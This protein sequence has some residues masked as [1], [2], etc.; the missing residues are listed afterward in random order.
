[1]KI[2]F[3]ITM[4]VY[5]GSGVATYTYN[6]VSELLKNDKKNEYHLFYSS[7]RRPKNF[8]YLDELEKLG[9]YIHSWRFPPRL[10]KLWWGKWHI[11]P[12]EWFT[13]KMDYFHTS[14]FLRPP[15]IKGTVGITTIHDLTWKI[16]PQWHT[17]D[18]IKAHS[19]KLDKT[20]KYKDIILCPSE[21]TKKDLLKLYPKS[22]NNKITVIYEGVD[23]KFKPIP[24][25][26]S[27]KILKKYKILKPYLV[28]IGAIEPRKNLKRL[29]K[30]FNLLIKEKR[31][32]NLN[33]VIGG[34]AGWK[35]QDVFNLVNKLK[36]N[37]KIIFTV[38][39]EDEDLASI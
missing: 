26:N 9:G 17:E 35:N 12:I 3:D 37:K 36:L 28:Y 16:Y 11:I 15:L 8:Y 33:L 5:A 22:K 4:L 19:L 30:A 32:S 2:G 14:D 10:L 21:Y 20:I 7:L 34:R 29:I 31:Y 25:K 39:I 38:F 18:V 6:L 27:L 24:L 1:M 23:Q 13:G